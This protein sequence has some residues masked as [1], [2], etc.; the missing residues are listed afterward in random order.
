[1]NFFDGTIRPVEGRLSFI[2]GK[3]AGGELTFP[4]GGFTLSVPLP[5]ADR[6]KA[7]VDRPVVL[8]IRP[9]HI[10]LRPWATE[11]VDGGVLAAKMEMTINVIE[12]LGG[13][14]DVYLSTALH[15]TVVGRMKAR[16]GLSAGART[17]VFVESSR[18]QF[19]EPGEA[20]MNLSL[21]KASVTGELTHALY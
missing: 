2:E 18:A 3:L 15:E 6:M 9:E 4:P 16:A 12:P 19:F 13:D 1:M 14:M 8:G 7:W 5:Q 20:G 10:H 17:T 11:V 21:E